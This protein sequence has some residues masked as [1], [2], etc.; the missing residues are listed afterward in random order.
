MNNKPENLVL[1]LF[2]LT[3][4]AIVVSSWMAMQWLEAINWILVGLV[5]FAGLLFLLVGIWHRK[6][7]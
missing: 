2:T 3:L 4:A 6:V 7:M 1:K 5:V